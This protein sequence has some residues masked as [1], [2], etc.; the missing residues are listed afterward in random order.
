MRLI[1]S[2]VRKDN[3]KKIREDMM[4][5]FMYPPDV[6]VKDTT[7]GGT[8]HVVVE[9]GPKNKLDQQSIDSIIDAVT[10]RNDYTFFSVHHADEKPDA[11]ETVGGWPSL[12]TAF[13]AKG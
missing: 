2:G 9:G 7:T 4:A 11:G 3:E 5:A 10:T 13:Q 12:E 6:V 1:L 8:I